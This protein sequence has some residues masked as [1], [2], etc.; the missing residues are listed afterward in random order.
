MS[1]L[2]G[3]LSVT[4]ETQQTVFPHQG[5]MGSSSGASLLLV[6]EGCG[7]ERGLEGEGG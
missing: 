6:K 5:S 2:T 1:L 3:P 4:M 7:E